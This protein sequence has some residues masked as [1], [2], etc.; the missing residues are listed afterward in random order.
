MLNRR[1][2][3]IGTTF[4][5]AALLVNKQK[6]VLS[7]TDVEKF[8]SKSQ[9]FVLFDYRLAKLGL[10]IG[11]Q[12][13]FPTQLSTFFNHPDLR[14][15]CTDNLKAQEALKALPN[16]MGFITLS[17][18]TEKTYSFIPVGH[19]KS[20][21]KVCWGFDHRLPKLLDFSVFSGIVALPLT[22][23][24]HASGKSPDLV[25]LYLRIENY[26][27]MVHSNP[28]V[29]GQMREFALANSQRSASLEL[30]KVKMKTTL[31]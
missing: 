17:K 19:H 18:W 12:P 23:I 11:L 14:L 1:L 31:G 7:E 29:I 21:E 24:H 9:K 20:H 28:Q 27:Q 13:E 2:F 6:T 16:C 4:T 15:L 3:L 10:N 30:E 22:A 8:V 25:D 26:N 5:A